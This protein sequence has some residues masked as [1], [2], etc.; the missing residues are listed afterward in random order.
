VYR[1]ELRP[2]SSLTPRAAAFFYLS[3]AA[4]SLGIAGGFAW[5]GFWPILPFAGLEL[6]GLAAALWVTQRRAGVREY[7]Q[8]DEDRV[9]FRREAS[10]RCLEREFRRPWVRVEMRRAP[11]AHW[12]SRLLLGSHGRSVE[13]GA[14]LTEDERV[15]LRDRLGSV[16]ASEARRG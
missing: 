1:F 16:L 7:V 9:T 15:A 14:F 5:L 12:P 10:G 6:A 8:V 11:V 4:M 2:N 3:I 13:V